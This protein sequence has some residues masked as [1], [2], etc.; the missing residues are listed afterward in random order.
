MVSEIKKTYDNNI[1][2]GTSVSSERLVPGGFFNYTLSY[3]YE[4][5]D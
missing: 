5:F 4:Y 3:E 2:T 1:I